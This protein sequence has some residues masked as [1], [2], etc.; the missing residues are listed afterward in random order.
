M[1]EENARVWSAPLAIKPSWT[2]LLPCLATQ[3]SNSQSCSGSS[4][5]ISA[6]ALA[7]LIVWVALL[8]NAFPGFENASGSIINSIGCHAVRASGTNISLTTHHQYFMSFC[9][10]Y[11]YA[12]RCPS[13]SLLDDWPLVMSSLRTLPLSKN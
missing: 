10:V 4:E 13:S 3:N 9:R 2:V 7:L 6:V 5:I 8:R 1:I 11:R 12:L